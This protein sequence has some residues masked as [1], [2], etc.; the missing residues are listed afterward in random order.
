M[1]GWLDNVYLKINVK[2]DNRLVKEI[3]YFLSR[4]IVVVAI[5]NENIKNIGN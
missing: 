3:H 4:P 5:W 1:S 2:S